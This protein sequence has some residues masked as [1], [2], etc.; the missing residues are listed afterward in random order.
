MEEKRVKAIEEI[1]MEDNKE[2][3]ILHRREEE[4]ESLSIEIVD[5]TQ[6]WTLLPHQLTSRSVSTLSSPPLSFLLSSPPPPPS[7]VEAPPLSILPR[8]ICI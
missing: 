3:R 2:R 6:I 5:H 7:L 4:E 1:L 8:G